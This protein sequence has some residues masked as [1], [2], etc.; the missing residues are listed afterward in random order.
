MH[1]HGMKVDLT[2]EQ[3][4]ALLKALNGIIE[5]DR[6]FLSP[7]I[8]TLKAIRSKLRPEPVRQPLPPEDTRPVTV[9][10][11]RD[12]FIHRGFGEG[13]LTTLSRPPVQYQ[14]ALR[15]VPAIYAPPPLGPG[16][17]HSNFAAAAPGA[18]Q[19]SAPMNNRHFGTVLTRVSCIGLSMAA[20]R[21]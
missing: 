6:Y 10:Y 2:D 14:G 1:I 21:P 18:D 16:H 17:D 11:K 19:P 15:A 3:A 13:R 12:L 4:A 9:R 8:Q 20:R 7:R 5:N